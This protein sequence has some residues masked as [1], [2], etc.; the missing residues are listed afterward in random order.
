L[1]RWCADLAATAQEAVTRTLV[2]L[3]EVATRRCGTRKLVIAGGVG[4]NCT[5]NGA[6]RRSG[7]VD[8][9]FIVPAAH[10]AGGALGAAMYV[11]VQH[12]PVAP[13]LGA[14][15]GPAF[16]DGQVADLLRQAGLPF[17]EPREVAEYAADLLAVGRVVGWFQGRAEVGP[18]ALGQRSILALPATAEVRDR[19]NKIKGREL[20]RP[21]SPSVLASAASELLDLGS[22]NGPRLSPFMLMACPTTER[23]RQI[24]T[25][26]VHVDGTTRP[27]TVT[28]QE[29][30]FYRLIEG[31]RARTGVPAVLNTSF[32]MEE[33]PIVCVPRDA[34]RTFILSDLDALVIGGLVVSKTRGRGSP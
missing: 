33:E 19:V 27:Q 17:S 28:D 3:A 10:D 29:G 23:A 16:A 4:L 30:L 21:L 9:L 18:R 24:A 22:G 1:P 11:S 25:A 14:D 26:V 31:V 13:L 32:N 8:D 7:L 12:G 15:Y 6:I 5:A 20:W 2:H 34:V